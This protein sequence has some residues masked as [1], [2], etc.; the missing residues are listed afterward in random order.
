MEWIQIN[1][2]IFF[3]YC[4]QFLYFIFCLIFLYHH[5]TPHPTMCK[6]I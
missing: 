4:M 2:M 6:I 1:I 5:T 3:N